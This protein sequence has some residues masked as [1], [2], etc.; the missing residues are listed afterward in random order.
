MGTGS[1]RSSLL[2]YRNFFYGASKEYPY[3]QILSYFG[4]SLEK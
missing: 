4:S 3:A 2:G 1:T